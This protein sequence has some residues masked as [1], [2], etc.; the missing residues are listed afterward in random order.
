M[1][2]AAN[3]Q[4]IRAEIAAACLRAA[5]DPEAVRLVAVSKTKSAAAIS[6]AATAGQRIFGESYVQE[7]LDKS[8]EVRQAV[9]W[10]FVG[11][12]QSNKVKYLRDRV[13]LIHSVDRLSLAREIDRQWARCEHP[14]AVLMQVNLGDEDSKSGIA[15][16]Q[17]ADLAR[18]IAA[19]PHLRLRGLMTLP[20]YFDDPEEVRPFFRRLRLLADEIAA[21]ALPG[22]R[23]EELSMG[24]SHDFTVA[25]EEGATLVRIGTAIFG[26]RS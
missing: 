5:R 21:L 24:M 13:T 25:I 26:S 19:L 16:D 20:P 11:H 8:P 9:E 4:Q 22:V 12:L 3:L 17:A 23:M 15:P 1:N 6:E 18:A 14:L 10:H 2:I 7:F